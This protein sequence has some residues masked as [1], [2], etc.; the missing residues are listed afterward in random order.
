MTS[1]DMKGI[2]KEDGLP[3]PSERLLK[4]P[5]YFPNSGVVST[6]WIGDK[7]FNACHIAFT[8]ESSSVLW[9]R[10]PPIPPQNSLPARLRLSIPSRS[11]SCS[12][13]AISDTLASSPRVC[14]S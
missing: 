5:V 12:A 7:Y 3:A 2:G 11:V 14:R 10:T 1:G 6:I 4:N 8:T 13:P 9:A